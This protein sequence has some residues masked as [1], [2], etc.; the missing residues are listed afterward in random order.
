M[1]STT[2]AEQKALRLAYEAQKAKVIA[3]QEVKPEVDVIDEEAEW[4]TLLEEVLDEARKA[5]G[6]YEF[7]RA[8]M[9]CEQL[10]STDGWP[11]N[12]KLQKGVEE[13][14]AKIQDRIARS[15]K[16]ALQAE[17][18]AWHTARKNAQRATY[19]RRQSNIVSMRELLS[20][21]RSSEWQEKQRRKRP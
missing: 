8:Y 9:L 19:T 18:I 3:E 21:S 14:E 7:A 5:Q 16:A 4:I 6:Y 15:Q 17:L 12:E 20:S 1:E 11:Q 10:K 13:I 2:L